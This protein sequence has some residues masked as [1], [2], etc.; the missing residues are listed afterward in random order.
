VREK[1]HRTLKLGFLIAVFLILLAGCTGGT[2]ADKV[3]SSNPP[4]AAGDSTSGLVQTSSSGGVTIEVE[5]RGQTG[6]SLEFGVSMDTHSGSL[7]YNLKDLAVLRDSSGQEYKPDTWDAPSGGH[8]VS[9]TLT[10][11]VTAS[12][13]PATLKYI[14]LTINDVAG[15]AERSF[16]WQLN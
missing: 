8:H 14:E 1:F 10:F 16:R 7:D 4:S 12:F 13:N 2:A 11:P 15:V 6:N 5:W 9:G 3:N